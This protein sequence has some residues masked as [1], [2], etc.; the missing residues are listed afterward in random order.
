MAAEYRLH[1]P[2]KA[3][4]CDFSQ[5]AWAYLCAGGSLPSLP[6]TIDAR[7]LAAL[8][9]MQPWNAGSGTNRWTLRQ[10]GRQYL[11]Y[12][13]S[14]GM[15]EFDLTPES[16][17]YIVHAVNLRTGALT[18]LAEQIAAGKTVTLPKSS[19]SPAV[20]WLTREE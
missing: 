8:P 1:Y 12:L 11:V 18:A 7:L 13:G 16:G 10:S 3:I 19:D 5:G 2:G 9:Q 14:G 17:K 15:N 20:L 4:I 6:R